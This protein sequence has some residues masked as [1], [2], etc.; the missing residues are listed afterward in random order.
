[1]YIVYLDQSLKHCQLQHQYDCM[2][3]ERELKAR[4]ITTSI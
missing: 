3:N 2:P 1:L 4:L